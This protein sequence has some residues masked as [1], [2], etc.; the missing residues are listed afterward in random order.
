VPKTIK[1]I[2]N[3]MLNQKTSLIVPGLLCSEVRVR[4]SAFGDRYSVL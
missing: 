3:Y 2:N 4:Y 1:N